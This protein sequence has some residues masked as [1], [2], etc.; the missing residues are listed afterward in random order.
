ME[1]K[2]IELGFDPGWVCLPLSAS[3]QHNCVPTLAFSLLS[4]PRLATVLR[5]VNLKAE[6]LEQPKQSQCQLFAWE[7]EGMES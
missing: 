2:W 7:M 3:L 4:P 1:K 5:E 6:T